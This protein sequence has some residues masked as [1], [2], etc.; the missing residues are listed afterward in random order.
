[1]TLDVQG[2]KFQ[3]IGNKPAAP[4]GVSAGSGEADVPGDLEEQPF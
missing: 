2:D 1:M 4:A 3:F